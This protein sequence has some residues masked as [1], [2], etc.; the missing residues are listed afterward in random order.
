MS[1][2]RPRPEDDNQDLNLD[3]NNN[4]NNNKRQKTD[5]DQEEQHKPKIEYLESCTQLLASEG[6]SEEENFGCVRLPDLLY[7]DDLERIVQFNFTVD[8]EYLMENIHPKVRSKIPIT[9]IHGHRFD[10]SKRAIQAMLLFFN[11]KGIQS[12]RMV[13]CTANLCQADWETM[14][15]GIYQ[16]PYCPLKPNKPT[17]N[18]GG[19]VGSEYGSRFERDLVNYMNAYNT[20]LREIRALVRLYDWSACKGILIGSVPGY[21]K[22]AAMELWGLQKLANV[23]RTHVSLDQDCVKDGSTI[24]AQCSSVG[25]LRGQWFQ[26]DFTRCM[27]EAINASK[28]KMPEIKF[29][30]PTV[31][32]VCQ[33]HSG[34]ISSAGFL[35]LEK[36]VYEQSKN[37][38]DTHLCKWISTESGRQKIMPHIKTYTRVYGFNS[39]AWHLLTSANLSRAAWGE[40]QKGNTQL[41]IK[42]F[43]LGVFLCPSLFETP[44]YTD[45]Q[46]LAATVHNPKP[47]P[48]TLSNNSMTTTN[49]DGDEDRIT[50][51]V[52]IRLPYDLPVEAYRA[53]DKCYTRQYSRDACV[54]LF[55]T[56]AASDLFD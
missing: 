15:Q 11:K 56:D 18:Q 5:H 6:V 40:F 47:M 30:Y 28:A 42:S 33:S 39:I 52:P 46:L 13:V 16:T 53:Q 51:I 26:R 27:S 1:S 31:D 20:S 54:Q 14:T 22:G 2:S 8:L 48:I 10:E 55:G 4:N 34:I 19:V 29:M 49:E 25:S 21:H 7:H 50:G 12:V 24:I 38:L 32:E 37:W 44:E 45:I 3:N 23:L 43:E 41:H 36:G 9:V 35:R 17:K